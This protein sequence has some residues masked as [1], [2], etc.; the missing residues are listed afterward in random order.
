MEKNI[1]TIGVLVDKLNLDNIKLEKEV[2][3]NR[4]RRSDDPTVSPFEDT[5]LN[6]APGSETEKL[7]NAMRDFGKSIG[8]GLEEYW[9]QIHEYMESTDLHY[10]G[11]NK[12]QILL[13]WVYYVK[14]PKD[15]GDLVFILD[16]KDYRAP[17]YVHKPEQGTFIVFPSWIR[18]KVTKNL[19]KD[20]RISIAGDFSINGSK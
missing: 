3:S 13:S 12:N 18:H 16:D 4:V 5:I 19:S 1:F 17:T 20:Y 11:D 6:V 2:L 7:I 14:T 9:S 8:L 10:H 15:S